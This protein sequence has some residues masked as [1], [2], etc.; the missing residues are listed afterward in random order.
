MPLLL[1]AKQLF[2]EKSLYCLHVLIKSG[3]RGHL[4]KKPVHSVS[5]SSQHDRLK[6]N[7]SPL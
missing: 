4:V 1:K 5:A 7:A 2:P 3:A 6:A